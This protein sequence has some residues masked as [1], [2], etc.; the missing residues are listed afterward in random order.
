VINL[1]VDAEIAAIFLECFEN[2]HFLAVS[3]NIHWPWRIKEPVTFQWKTPVF[4]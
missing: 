4:K 3:Y 1:G 2:M